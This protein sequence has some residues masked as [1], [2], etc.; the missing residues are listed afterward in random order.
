[1]S[2]GSAELRVSQWW[3]HSKSHRHNMREWYVGFPSAKSI[4]EPPTFCD[5]LQLEEFFHFRPDQ[6]L[7]GSD[8]TRHFDEKYQWSFNDILSDGRTILP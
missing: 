3:S 7:I 5:K 1:M 4:S 8:L 2:I 6:V